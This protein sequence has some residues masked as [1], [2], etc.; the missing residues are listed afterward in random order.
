MS[1]TNKTATIELSQ[2]VGT[3]K[4]TYLVDY[5]GDM[6]KI[7]NAI[8]ADRDSISTA[9][10]T[11]DGAVTKADA[12]KDSIDAIN[13]QLNGDPETPGDAGLA[14]DV[15]AV[16]GV[17]NT[18]TSLIGT[19]SPTT[20]E[21]TII[22][23]I[24]GIE[25]AIAPRE[26]GLLLANSYAQG[27]QFARGGTVYEALTS[28]TAGAA[29][30]SLVLNTDYKVADTLVEQI[31]NAGGGAEL[32]NGYYVKE[33]TKV[34]ATADGV[35]TIKDLL[36]ELGTNFRT[37]ML[38]LENDEFALITNVV[39]QNAANVSNA[40]Y[41]NTASSLL[42]IPYSFLILNTNEIIT[43]YGVISPVANYCKK[44]M[45]RITTTP[46]VTYED[47]TNSLQPSV[48]E[49]FEIEYIVYKQFPTT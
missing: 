5:N 20:S 42:T 22:G 43:I 3:D 46:A 17:V 4:P 36:N 32:P 28:L 30:A 26:D 21:Q 47:Q 41:D 23:A 2:Y 33:K 18:V 12:N 9:Q 8:A 38:A 16:E 1:S 44:M 13:V 49:L 11:A 35:K 24:N 25:G 48:G 34:T 39:A 27:E 29:F 15:N 37:A 45:G 31:A 6:L 10:S 14:G 7:D 40:V 19:G